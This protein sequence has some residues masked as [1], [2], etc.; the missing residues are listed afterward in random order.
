MKIIGKTSGGIGMP[1]AFSPGDHWIVEILGRTVHVPTSVP[2]TDLK[3]A[4][5]ERLGLTATEVTEYLAACDR[6]A[7]L[8]DLT[9][10]AQLIS[11][12]LTILKAL[13]A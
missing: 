2:E 9:P 4:A 6:L 3:A 7:E 1:G 8:T 12:I 5:L 13:Q 11:D 10:T